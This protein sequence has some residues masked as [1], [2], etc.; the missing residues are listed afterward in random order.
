MWSLEYSRNDCE[1]SSR[2]A[3]V[4]VPEHVAR[5]MTYPERVTAHNMPKLRALILNGKD[6]HPGANFVRPSSDNSLLLPKQVL[7]GNK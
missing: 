1:V 3:Q 6:K 4:G 5:V 2:D 7:A